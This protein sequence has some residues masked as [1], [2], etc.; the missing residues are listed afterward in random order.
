[1]LLNADA[2][3]ALPNNFSPS[4][5]AN[6]CR[7][8]SLSIETRLSLSTSKVDAVTPV[9]AKSLGAVGASRQY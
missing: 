5:P 8:T 6:S 9:V 1:M 3:A 2:D 7:N 4:L